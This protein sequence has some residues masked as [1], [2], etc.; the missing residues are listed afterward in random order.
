[1]KG[2]DSG[3][4]V[5]LIGE[6]LGQLIGPVVLGLLVHNTGWVSAGYLMI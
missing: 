6:N 1:M 2:I 4:A 3:L 5:V